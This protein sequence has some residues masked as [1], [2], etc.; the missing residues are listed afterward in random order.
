MMK[1]ILK[2]IIIMKKSTVLYSGK[3]LDG[4]EF[5]SNLDIEDPFVFRIG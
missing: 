3:L 5:D 2:M 4:T 1:Y